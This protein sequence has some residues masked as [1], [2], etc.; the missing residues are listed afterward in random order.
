MKQILPIALFIVI[1]LILMITLIVKLN[2]FQHLNEQLKNEV[3]ELHN[4]K[5]DLPEELEPYLIDIGD[6]LEVRCFYNN[7]TKQLTIRF[8]D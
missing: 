6:T 8:K 5:L 7:D 2:Q 4:G 3:I 1:Y